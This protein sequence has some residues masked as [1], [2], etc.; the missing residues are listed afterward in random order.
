METLTTDP[1]FWYCRVK[2]V[3]YSFKE[4]G[5]LREIERKTAAQTAK[6]KKNNS[7]RLA[8]RETVEFNPPIS[9]KT[10]RQK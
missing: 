2:N 4:G 5:R 6:K 3:N 7:Q 9:I 10:H 8:T 1:V